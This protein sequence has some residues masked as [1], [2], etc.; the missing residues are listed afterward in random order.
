MKIS[1]L[2]TFTLFSALCYASPSPESKLSLK[3][4]ALA[5]TKIEGLQKALASDAQ[6]SGMLTLKDPRPEV[7][8]RPWMYFASFSAQAFQAE[9]VATKEGSGVFNLGKNGATVMPSIEL[10]VISHPWKTAAL[11]WK[12]GLRSKA[13][14]ASQNTEV[15]LPSGY[16]INDARLN[17]TLFSGGAVLAASWERFNWLTLN[18]SPLIGKL[19]YTQTSSNEFASFS[20]H[21]DFSSMGVGFDIAISKKWSVF[22]EWSQRQLN[23][24]SEIALQKDNFEFGTKVLW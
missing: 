23:G 24:N 2:L 18:V 1:L 7:V 13:H 17:T 14:L 3:E 15:T 11:N 9:G 22:S 10:G 12:V 4:Q 16:K 6:V 8:T 21:A 20:K 5:E 19:S